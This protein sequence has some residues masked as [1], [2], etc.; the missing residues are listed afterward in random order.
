MLPPSVWRMGT[1]KLEPAVMKLAN[2]SATPVSISH[3]IQLADRRSV[4]ALIN[5]ARFLHRELP[6]RST[7]HC[8]FGDGM[9]SVTNGQWGW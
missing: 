2:Q 4:K 9:G 3:L 8:I 7:S 5:N 6:I 1:T